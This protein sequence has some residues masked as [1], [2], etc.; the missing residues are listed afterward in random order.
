MIT[1]IFNK[2]LRESYKLL[3]PKLWGKSV[4][5]NGIPTI[6]NI[7]RLKFGRDVS[8]NSNCYIQCVG[9]GRN[10]RLCDN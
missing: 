4:Q 8:L 2:F 3:R 7:E 9:G 5:I 6:G 1:R 10:M